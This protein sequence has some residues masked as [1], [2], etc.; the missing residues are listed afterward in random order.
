MKLEG[1]VRNLPDTEYHKV[2]PPE[3]AHYSSSQFKDA[4][5]DV[6]Y[7][8]KKYITKTIV[9]EN[10]STTQGNFDVGSA[11][12]CRILEPEKFDST[13]AIYDGVKRGKVYDQFVIDNEGKTI[14]SEK[15][16]E[17]V[18]FLEKANRGNKVAQR[19]L[20]KGE[21]EVS[22][23]HV[24][25]GLRIKVRADWAMFE[26]IVCEKTGEV[27]QGTFIMDLKS[28]TGN[29]KS[30]KDIQKKISSLNYDLSAA[31]YMDVFNDYLAKNNLPLIEEWK[32][33]FD[34]KDTGTSKVWTASK[35]MLEVGRRKYMEAL[36][37]IKD[38]MENG[39]CFE[40][41]D[42]SIDPI[43]YDEQ[44]WLK[45]KKETTILPALPTVADED[46]L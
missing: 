21:P 41:E 36:K 8:H 19:L 16:L 23:F 28:T 45:D 10:S 42:S 40:D 39:W 43:S 15:Q 34:S 37:N 35:K 31:L 24:L 46:L 13:F 3:E 22:L 44:E 17:I 1:L 12:H 38:N 7:F 29:P 33:C 20:A 9:E 2:L 6:E 26:P 25:H 27:T 18:N 14:L 4:L 32:F 5:E 11:Y 30:K